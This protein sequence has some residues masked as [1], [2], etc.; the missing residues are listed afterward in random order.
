M[1]T[2]RGESQE[3]TPT[4]NQIRMEVIKG[5]MLLGCCAPLGVLLILG[6]NFHP[7]VK[8]ALFLSFLTGFGTGHVS[9]ITGYK[10][11]RVNL[12]ARTSSDRRKTAR[13]PTINLTE[14]L[15]CIGN[16]VHIADDKTFA[17]V[18]SAESTLLL[19]R[20]VSGQLNET[21]L[22]L[23]A[24]NGQIQDKIVVTGIETM[25]DQNFL[26]TCQMIEAVH[27]TGGQLTNPD[28][29]KRLFSNNRRLIALAEI[30]RKGF[31]DLANRPW[32]LH[33]VVE[34]A[35]SIPIEKSPEV[36]MKLVKTVTDCLKAIVFQEHLSA[37]V[38]RK[39]SDI[40]TER[41][42][43][44]LDVSFFS[45]AVVQDMISQ[46]ISAGVR[47]IPDVK[48]AVLRSLRELEVVFTGIKKGR[49]LGIAPQVLC[50]LRKAIELV[51]QRTGV[52][53]SHLAS[54]RG[55]PQVA[56]ETR[57]G[58]GL[59]ITLLV[60]R[61]TFTLSDVAEILLR[62]YYANPK[63]NFFAL[64]VGTTARVG[65]HLAAWTG[66]LP[67]PAFYFAAAD[68]REWIRAGE[69]IDVLERQNMA[70]KHRNDSLLLLLLE[71]ILI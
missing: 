52:N 57:E 54:H 67:D 9:I 31:H 40:D 46:L 26:A 56:E 4:H 8:T 22:A 7:T 37:D 41:P 58:D 39:W 15:K 61:K 24:G 43:N 71:P 21:A 19:A 69:P 51:D 16:L 10:M 66:P 49:L 18:V 59:Q 35:Q 2:E 33:L 47:P 64:A 1:T 65:V 53:T 34:A 62:C 36:L 50:E 5:M 68:I 38:P 32:I 17:Q 29:R 28:Q 12:A 20:G 11:Y 48:K 23:H 60:F 44:A 14:A 63:T 42:R 30:S 27:V 13:E 6:D 55:Y 25:S 45:L 70:S 3:V